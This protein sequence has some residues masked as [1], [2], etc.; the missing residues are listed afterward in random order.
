M[1]YLV[2]GSAGFIGFHVAKQLIAEG[3][4]VL[5]ID[6]MTPYYDV[7]LKRRRHEILLESTSFS[8]QEFALEDMSSLQTAYANNPPDVVI[9][10]A[11]QAGV[12][13]SLENPR[14]YIDSNVIGTFNVLEL[15]RAFCPKHVLLASTSSVYGANTEMPFR[16]QDRA[17]TQLTIYAAT[18]KAAEAMAHSYAHL[19]GVPTTVFRFFSVYGPWGRPDMALF[20]F[21]AAILRGEPIKL[22]NGGEMERDFTFVDDITQAILLLS[23]IP[24]E[25][26]ADPANASSKGQSSVGPFRVV[27]IGNGNPIPLLRFVEAIE[28]SLGKRAEREL[29]PMQPGD[30]PATFADNTLLFDLTGFRPATTVEDGV[31][32]FIRWYR[33]YHAPR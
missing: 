30:V 21:T 11:A 23:S 13:Y 12:R 1:R 24:P 18:K 20:L 25:I 26:A 4:E 19:F 27:N 10:L 9:H 8:A 22:F 17:D 28:K 29:L 3:H 2:T 14:A 7:Q 16:E 31:E 15:A 5:G 6:A 33:D 32:Q